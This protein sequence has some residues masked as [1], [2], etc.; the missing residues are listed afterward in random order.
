MNWM[1]TAMAAFAA[2]CL[3][4]QAA[5]AAETAETE[6]TLIK[7]IRAAAQQYDGIA[8]RGV[9]QAPDLTQVRDLYLRI[10]KQAAASGSHSQTMREMAE[11]Y[12]L[13]GGEPGILANWKE[14]LDPGSTEG[15]IF[16]GVLAY[17]E[18]KT[19]DAETKLLRFDP[20]SM[21][22]WRGGHLALAQALLTVR[23]DAKRAFHYLSI[24]ALLLPGTLVEEAALRQSAILAARTAGAAEFSTAITAYFRRFPRSAYLPGFEGQAVF[25]IVRFGDKDGSRILQDLLYALPEGWGRCLSCFLTTI[26]EQALL[27]GKI[28]L[29]GNASAAAMPLAASDSRERQRLLIYSGAAMFLGGKFQDG[30][31][32]LNSVQPAK[33]SENDRSLLDATLAVTDKVRKTPVLLSQAERSAALRPVKGNRAFPVSGPEE[34]ARRALAAAETTLNSAQ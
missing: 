11:V 25:Y 4:L 14:G 3:P 23:T 33:L 20:V 19:M 6:E 30:L 9:S 18:G 13:S 28:E 29:A 12:V 16:E 15:K 8:D 10:L 26:A 27:T 5:F 17:G 24:A 34:A 2:L 31:A 1:R 32:S 21:T 7:Q 22:P